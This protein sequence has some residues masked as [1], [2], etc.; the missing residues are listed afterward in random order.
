MFVRHG[1][2][3]PNHK[4]VNTSKKFLEKAKLYRQTHVD[5]ISPLNVLDSLFVTFQDTPFYGLSGLGKEEVFN[6]AQR[7]KQRYPALFERLDDETLSV[8]SSE[9]ERCV[10]SAKHFLR[11][12]HP[13]ADVLLHDKIVINNK[14]MRLFSECNRYIVGV[15]TNHS[16][17]EHLHNF[18]HGEQMMKVVENFKKRHQISDM[19]VESGIYN[20]IQID[21]TTFTKCRLNSRILNTTYSNDFSDEILKSK[22]L[23]KKANY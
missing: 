17:T 9:K 16:A 21:H 11:G 14:M 18:K 10:D 12:L 8:V 4:Q 2:R 13:N 15:D 22:L 20:R 23:R 19:N 1:A 6:I 5:H 3:Y 7:Y